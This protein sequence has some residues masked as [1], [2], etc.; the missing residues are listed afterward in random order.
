MDFY[1]LGQKRSNTGHQTTNS[2]RI[3]F[4]C[5]FSISQFKI[6]LEHREPNSI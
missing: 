5:N 6:A 4:E 2:V 1:V 3:K